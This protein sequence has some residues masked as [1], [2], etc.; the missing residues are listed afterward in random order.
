M[1]ALHVAR[2]AW[3][4]LPLALAL[5]PPTPRSIVPSCLSRRCCHRET[6]GDAA[7]GADKAEAEGGQHEGK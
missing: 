7:A 4:P 5:E 3:L 2:Y 1:S 6:Q